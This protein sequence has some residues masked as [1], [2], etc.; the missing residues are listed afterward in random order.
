MGTSLNRRW[1]NVASAP[2]SGDV[3]CGSALAGFLGLGA[4]QDGMTFNGVTFLDGS[5]WEERNGCVYTH[6]TTTL[7]RGTLEESSAGPTTPI[8][9]S[10]STTVMLS[11]SAETMNLLDLAM[12]SVIPG[13]R[14]TTESGV[15][16]STSDRTSQSTIYYTP[17]VHDTV[18]LWDGTQ[19]KPVKFPETSLA[20]SGLT[21]GKPYDVFGYLS[22]G[23]LALELLAWTGDTTRATAVTL[24]DGRYCKSG[25]KTRLLLGTIYTTGT[26]TTADAA[27]TRY[28]GNV[29]NRVACVG[30]GSGGYHTYTTGTRREWNGGSGVT[31]SRAVQP[32]PASVAAIGVVY[33][34]R[35][36]PGDLGAAS[37]SLNSTTAANLGT[38]VYVYMSV[39]SVQDLRIAFGGSGNT[40]AGLNFVT[41]TQTGFSGMVFSTTAFQVTWSL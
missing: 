34:Q 17:F 39:A 1:F 28:V 13:G 36:G 11:V 21:S 3:A 35:S 8:S 19:W 23:V 33:L 7:T 6:S 10:A 31:R 30:T 18:P 26:T 4:A 14:L 32:I 25:G 9:L 20:L 37:L 40:V 38:D 5:A 15:P 12:Q 24:Q 16:V 29:Y 27:A 2:G 22:S 41:P